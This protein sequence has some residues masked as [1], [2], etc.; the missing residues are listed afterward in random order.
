MAHARPARARQPRVLFRHIYTLSRC[1][2]TVQGHQLTTRGNRLALNVSSRE[3]SWRCKVHL[4]SNNKTGTLQ[5]VIPR[6]GG[7]L[8]YRKAEECWSGVG[9]DDAGQRQP[10]DE[11]TA[12]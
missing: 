11:G 12:V 2:L 8:V 9:F 1:K 10:D 6:V 7:Q 5:V 4:K 3:P